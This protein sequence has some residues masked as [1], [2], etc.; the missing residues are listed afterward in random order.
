MTAKD[1]WMGAGRSQAAEPAGAAHE[2]V[3]AALSAGSDPK[4]VM[5]FA[6]ASASYELEALLAAAEPGCELVGCT[7][8]GELTA[9]GPGSD[10]VVA[11]ALG[12]AGFSVAT[13]SAPATGRMREAGAEV[14]ACVERVAPR[15]HRILVLLPDG[16]AGDQQDLI[17]GAYSTAGASVPLVGGGAGDDMRLRSTRQLH[18]GDVLAGSVVAAAIGSDAPF[19][20]GVRHGWRATGD[21]MLVTSGRG[22]E[23]ATLDDRPAL[24]VFAERLGVP[25]ELAADDPAEFSRRALERPLGLSVR[26]DDPLIRFVVS[27]DTSTGALR[28]GAEVPQGMI[29]WLMEGRPEPMLD[30]AEASCDEAIAA[31]GGRD[32]IGLVAF[33]CVSR[34]RVLGE[35]GSAQEVERIARR[36]GGAPLAGFYTYGEIA[37]V[38]GVLGVH[39]QACVTLAI[40]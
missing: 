23:V 14:A 6:S 7:T 1:R 30:A 31:L 39:A 5:L 29:A 35:E 12:G 9:D 26:R 22:A 21:G 28:F 19:G 11:V 34:R 8:G 15:P 13:A 16:L 38:R 40:S 32:P 10:G 20:I 4:L 36:A 2:A 17:R 27:G 33:D 25:R 24:D 18:G 3:S 37:R